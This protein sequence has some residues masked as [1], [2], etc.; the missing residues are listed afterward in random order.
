MSWD[1]ATTIRD[2]LVALSLASQL[3]SLELRE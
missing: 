2:A 1:A 3:D